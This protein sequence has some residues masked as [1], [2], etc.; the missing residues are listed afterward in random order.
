MMA[1]YLTFL[2]NK[3]IAYRGSYPDENFGTHTSR[4]P[5]LPPSLPPTQ[6]PLYR[7]PPPSFSA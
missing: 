1:E 3:A 5:T 2:Q 6:T 7:T 4:A